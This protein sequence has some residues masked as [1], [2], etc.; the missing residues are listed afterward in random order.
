[1]N[2]SEQ[3]RWREDLLEAFAAAIGNDRTL[4]DA[5]VFK[6]ARVLALHVPSHSRASLDLDAAVRPGHEW[7]QVTLEAALTG[8]LRRRFVNEDPRRFEL[9]ALTVEPRPR[10]PHPR[11]WDGWI[12]KI[13]A[14][15]AGS[16][17]RNPPVVNV[18]LAASEPWREGALCQR[19]IG[20]ALVWTYTLERQLGEKGRALLKSLQPETKRA[21]RAKDVYDLAWTARTHP[22]SDASRLWGTAAHHFADACE[23]REVSFDGMPSLNAHRDAI[24]DSYVK[25]QTLNAVHFDEAWQALHAIMDLWLTIIG[26]LHQSDETTIKNR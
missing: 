3:Q 7:T 4:I 20:G 21:I 2:V 16:S 9:V 6:G 23:S 8:A 22:V 15:A 5:F 18:D 24:R 17:V 1:V 13:T 12:V 11:G 25:D 14:R 19:E 26:V 10:K